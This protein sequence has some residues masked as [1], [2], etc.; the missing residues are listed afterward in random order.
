MITIP[1]HNLTGYHKHIDKTDNLCYLDN[2]TKRLVVEFQ[3]EEELENLKKLKSH[4]ALRDE[5]M[6]SWVRSKIEETVG[7]T[8]KKKAAPIRQGE[9]VVRP[10][11]APSKIP[12]KQESGKTINPDNQCKK[13]GQMKVLGKCRNKDCK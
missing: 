6:S 13:C 4:L 11:V 7:L 12:P 1:A 3:T 5:S 8:S 2:M 10:T 9:K